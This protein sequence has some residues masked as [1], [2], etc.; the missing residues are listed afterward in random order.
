MPLQVRCP[1]CQKPLTI[2]DEVAGQ[3]VRCPGCQAVFQVAVRPAPEA[4]A[5]PPPAPPPQESSKTS[6][7]GVRRPVVSESE[8]EPTPRQAERRPAP[9]PKP[10]ARAEE[11]ADGEDP[12]ELDQRAGGA[13]GAFDWSE[14]GDSVLGRKKLPRG[15]ICVRRGMSF[16]TASMVVMLIGVLLAIVSALGS[17][18]RPGAD[19]MPRLILGGF[20]TLSTV[21]TLTG[22]GHCM[23]VPREAGAARGLSIAAFASSFTCILLPIGGILFLIFLNFVAR[24]FENRKLAWHAIYYL[25]FVCVGPVLVVAFPFVLGLLLQNENIIPAGIALL[26]FAFQI[27]TFAWYLLIVMEMGTTIDRARMGLRS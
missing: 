25:I 19:T 23:M 15:W 18:M 26:L 20:G 2:R 3:K 24:H 5:P 17:G 14:A 13:G 11:D 7:A 12:W 9:R 27:V 16:I 6:A 4:P 8:E 22:L 21:L 10:M 1:G